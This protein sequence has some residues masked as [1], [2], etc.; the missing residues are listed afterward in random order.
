[1]ATNRYED[2]KINIP[3]EPLYTAMEKVNTATE[4][5]SGDID[6]LEKKVNDGV[7]QAI[8]T[9]S[10]SAKMWAIILG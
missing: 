4:R 8:S 3:E 9:S 5:I 2:C 6:N 1:M 10:N 7:G